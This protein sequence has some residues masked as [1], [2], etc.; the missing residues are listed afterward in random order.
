MNPPPIRTPECSGTLPQYLAEGF[1]RL[2]ARLLEEL[3]RLEADPLDEEAVHDARVACRR[4][5]VGLLLVRERIPRK[6]RRKR[7]EVDLRALRTALG[8]ARETEVALTTLSGLRSELS[9]DTRLAA[10]AL[11]TALAVRHEELR[12]AAGQALNAVGLARFRRRLSRVSEGLAAGGDTA[13]PGGSTPHGSDAELTAAAGAAVQASRARLLAL[14]SG[15]I[16]AGDDE[17]LHR[18]RIEGKKLRYTLEFF[19]PLFVPRIRVRLR[20]LRQLQDQ[21]GE[22][23]D[24]ADLCGRL[25]ALIAAA[26][27]LH[28][29][30]LMIGYE[31]LRELVEQER[32]R[33][34]TG[35]GRLQAAVAHAGFIPRLA[36]GQ[37]ESVRAG[38]SVSAASHAAVLAEAPE[39]AS[40]PDD[41]DPPEA[42]GGDS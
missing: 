32:T 26:R 8:A 23:H 13:P 19:E 42:S 39:E 7:L 4:L 28:D 12:Q 40:A 14:P 6:K 38:S 21:L 29:A 33:R 37:T 10:D 11:S 5:R 24:L 31:A 15:P 1:G 22:I 27:K 18:L 34:L 9:G 3:D 36:P 16:L 30:R 17:A 35:V 2:A 25:D 20:M 41:D